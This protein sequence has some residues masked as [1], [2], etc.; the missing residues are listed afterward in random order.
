MV[1]LDLVTGQ[2]VWQS[3]TIGSGIGG[4]I[5][6]AGGRIWFHTNEPAGSRLVGL[7]PP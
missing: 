5:S 3:S 2:E 4:G 7:G 1:A 6:V